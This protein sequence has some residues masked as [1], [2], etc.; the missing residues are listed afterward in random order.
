MQLLLITFPNENSVGVQCDDNITLIRFQ[1]HG[2]KMLL[3]GWKIITM[4]N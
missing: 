4:L 1:Q 3:Q 2:T